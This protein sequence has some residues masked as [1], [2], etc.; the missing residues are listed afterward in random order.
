MKMSSLSP[1]HPSNLHERHPAYRVVAL[2]VAWLRLF[3]R[4]LQANQDSILFSVGHIITM[5]FS[6]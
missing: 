4:A 1:H 5:I 2:I 6:D 3:A